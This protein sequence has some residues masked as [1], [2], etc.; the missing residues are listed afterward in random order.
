MSYEE[1]LDT[2]EECCCCCLNDCDSE[3][4]KNCI[5][6]LGV[7]FVVGFGAAV[8]T[9]KY[10]KELLNLG[11]VYGKEAKKLSKKNVKKLEKVLNKK[12]NEV[13]KKI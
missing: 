8:L 1:D 6:P 7:A 11:E 5:I 10:R 4:K 12:L 9:Y 3:S 13:K 2:T